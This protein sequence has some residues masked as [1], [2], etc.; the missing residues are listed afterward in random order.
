MIGIYYIKNLVNSKIYVGKSE[1]SIESRLSQHMVGYNSNKHLKNSISKYGIENFET[2]VL[3]ECP[4]EMCSERERFWIKEL[5]SCKPGVGYNKTTGGENVSGWKMTDTS[6]MKGTVSEEHKRN[7]S[8]S[9][10]GNSNSKDY[11]SSEANR[12]K[13]SDT[14]KK[15]YQDED[16]R[17]RH[18]EALRKSLSKESTKAKMSESQIKR[19]DD[20]ERSRQRDNMVGNSFGKGRVHINNGI[21]RKMILKEE[22]DSYLKSGWV[23][24]RGR[25]KHDATTIESRNDN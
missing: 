6:N 3:E 18:K 24:G 21:S 12:V 2:G 1:S 23:I 5:G 17:M 4:R 8:I 14:I 11:Y 15:K 13:H 16:F 25:L 20:S 7:I 10:I 19:W 22:L 9:M